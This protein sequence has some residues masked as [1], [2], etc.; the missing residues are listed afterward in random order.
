MV[1]RVTYLLAPLVV[2]FV[3]SV[4]GNADGWQIYNDTTAISWALPYK[5]PG[6]SGNGTLCLGA[7]ESAASC[8]SKCEALRAS[9]NTCTA[10]TWHDEH[11]GKWS[12]LCYARI[13]GPRYCFLRVVHEFDVR[14]FTCAATYFSH[15]RSVD[16]VCGGRSHEWP[17]HW[18][19]RRQLPRG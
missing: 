19:R 18:R 15:Y 6:S 14:D 10:F 1:S 11:Q 8:R 17:L 4:R 12:H 3:P 7:T 9:N 16:A 13:N 5:P 2:C